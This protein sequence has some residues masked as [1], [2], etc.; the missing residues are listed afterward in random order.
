MSQNV[1]HVG[2]EVDDVHYHGSALD[3]YTGKVLEF[4]CHPMLKGLVGQLEIVCEYFGGMQL[5]LC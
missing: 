3:K 5:K 2:I 4:Q 1:V